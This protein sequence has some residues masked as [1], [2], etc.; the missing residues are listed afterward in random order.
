MISW[1]RSIRLTP[2]QLAIVAIA[3][4]LA[5]GLIIDAATSSSGVPT[6]MIVALRQRVVVHT[7]AS[8]RPAPA[9]APSAGANAASSSPSSTSSSSTAPTPASSPAVPTDSADSSDS[10]ASGDTSDSGDSTDSGASGD[11]S[12]SGDGSDSSAS[13][14]SGGSAGTGTSTSPASSSTPAKPAYKV[15]HVFVIAL[16]TTT[17]QATFGHGSVAHYLN[18][19]LRR[20]GTLLSGYETL[21]PAELPDYFGMVSGQASNPD[22]RADCPIYAE[23]PSGAKTAADGQVSGRGCIYPNTVLTI[24]DQVTA[25]GKVWNAYIDDMGSSPC[26]HPNSGAVD[27]VLL[28]GAGAQYATRHNPFIYFHSLLDLGDC[29]SDDVTLDR[30]PEA[31][32]SVAK[33][34]TY[35]FIT[36]GTCDDALAAVCPDGQPGGLAGEDAFLKLWVPRILASRAYQRDGALIIAF[37][38]SPRAPGTSSDQRPVRTGALILSRYA[39]R[40]H[41]VSGRYDP[42]SLLRSVEDLF[43]YT[44]LAHANTATSFVSTALPSAAVTKP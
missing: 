12:D 42:Y 14:D 6:A 2:K 18:D 20:R 5:T 15:K 26:L 31:L 25:S 40:G 37:T 22:T 11:T 38:T 13:G 16:S 3:S 17:Y 34:P 39:K 8:R 28:P 24:G 21:G 19:T 32:R 35:A 29:S 36:P 1:L 41:T 9:P 33:T 27:N 23:F 44:P 4:A 7:V 30:L 43:G 10:G